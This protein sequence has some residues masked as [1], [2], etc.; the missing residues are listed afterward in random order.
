MAIVSYGI[1]PGERGTALIESDVKH[2]CG[3]Y[4]IPQIM[5]IFCYALAHSKQIDFYG[6][7][8]TTFFIMNIAVPTT[9]RF[10]SEI[11]VKQS[12]AKI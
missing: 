2:G 11:G 12:S 7:P 9:E 4:I 8:A 10:G 5:L 1:I 3:S 6:C